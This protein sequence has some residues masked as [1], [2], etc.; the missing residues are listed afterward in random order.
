MPDEVVD[1]RTA[2][3]FAT[4]E[5]LRINLLCAATSGQ[6]TALFNK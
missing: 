2:R 6:T 1:R 5:G 4:G 3:Y